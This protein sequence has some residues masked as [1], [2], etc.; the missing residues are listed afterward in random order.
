MRWRN[1]QNMMDADRSHLHHK[2]MDKG[3]S[4][5][6]TLALLIAYASVCALLGLALENLAESLSLLI[7]CLLFV[8]HC[9]F[10]IKSRRKRDGVTR[11]GQV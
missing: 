1:G 8:G 11:W 7:Y 3:L 6:Q 9:L 4:A 5:R 2:L 10:V